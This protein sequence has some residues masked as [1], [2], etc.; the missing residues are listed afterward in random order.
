[1]IKKYYSLGQ[2]HKIFIEEVYNHLSDELK[3]LLDN[4]NIFLFLF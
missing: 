4:Y 2:S 3:N 1:M